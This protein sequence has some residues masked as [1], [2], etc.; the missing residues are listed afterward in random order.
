MTDDIL[1]CYVLM[2]MDLDSLNPGKAMAQAHHN[3]GALKSAIRANIAMAPAY[4]EW[5]K[6]STQDFGT[7][8]TLG[9]DE[10]GI[11]MA[12]DRVTAFH[13]PTK[14]VAGWV[15]DDS[16]P[17]RDGGITHKVRLNTNAFVFGLESE[18]EDIISHLEYHP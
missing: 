15:W 6:Q 1:I 5:Q 13:S 11:Q 9:G 17:V 7:V 8:I 12:L 10:R 16:Y 2:R 18:C 14:V 3:F 4:L